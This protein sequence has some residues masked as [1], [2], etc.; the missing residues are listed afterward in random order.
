MVN[1]MLFVFYIY[2]LFLLKIKA[3]ILLGETKI[4]TYM[5]K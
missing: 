3:F 4:M 2:Y 1:F 5:G